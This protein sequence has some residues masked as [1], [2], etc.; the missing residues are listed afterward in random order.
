SDPAYKPVVKHTAEKANAVTVVSE[1]LARKAHDLLG[2]KRDMHVI[3]NFID[4]K[5]FVP[6]QGVRLVVE[7]GCVSR[8]SEEE[9]E[10]IGAHEK[11]LLH[12]SNFRAVKR[13]VELVDIMKGVVE[14]VPDC[15]LLIAG[16]GPTRVN[17]E[18]RIEELNLCKKVHLLGVRSN[19]QELMCCADMFLL[20][21]TLEGMPL[22]LLEAMACRLPVVTTPAG[23]VPELVRPG[24]DGVVTEGFEKEEYVEA[25]VALLE[26]DKTR[27]QLASAGRKRVEDSF[28]SDKVV[29]M[30]ESV[31]EEALRR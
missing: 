29:P 22:V 18:R 11:I 21:S 20:N 27:R 13:V 28:S 5:Q 31:F 23:G 19:M 24:K 26:D 15:R 7:S 30:Y 1:F 6:R 3:P 10:R 9:A 12:A 25:V 8:R 4:V 17:V 16:D 14:R 2:V